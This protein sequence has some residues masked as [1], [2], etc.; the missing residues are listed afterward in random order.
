MKKIINKDFLKDKIKYI[1]DQ[2]TNF[3]K[4]NLGLRII[5]TVILA[6]AF[7]TFF[8]IFNFY[9]KEG[10]ISY[11]RIFI[12]SIIAFYIIS[13]F[14][15]NIRELY[16]FIYKKRYMISIVLVLLF[17]I[18][19]YNGSSI[20]E[21]NYYIQ[22]DVKLKEFSP[23]I[24]Q[25]RKIRTDEWST[26]TPIALSQDKLENKYSYYND[27]VR[28][29]KTDMFSLM[30]IPV[31]DILSLGKIFN[32]GYFV[33]INFGLS[34]WWF[35]RLFAL[36][37]VTFELCMM[38]T[39][40]NR[41]VSLMGMIMISFSAAVQWWFSTPIVEILIWGQLAVLLI[42]K[43]IRT[44][45][46][47]TK[48]KYTLLLFVCAISYVF[49][50]YPAWQISFG[51]I[52]LA[53]I[54]WVFIKNKNQI[55]INKKD[56]ILLLLFLVLVGGFIGRFIFKSGDSLKAMTSTVY[57]GERKE[58]GGDRLNIFSYIYNI[59]EPYESMGNDCEQASLF[60]LYPLPMLVSLVYI[61]NNKKGKDFIIPLL[62]VGILYTV[63]QFIG[64]GNFELLA[65]ITLL[66]NVPALRIA[67]PLALIQIYLMVYLIS[68]IKEKD[69]LFNER[70]RNKA[71]NKI[72]IIA[73]CYISIYI[74]F[75]INVYAADNTINVLESYLEINRYFKLLIII[76]TIC[77]TG[78]LLININR[79]KHK[80]ILISLLII[81]SL[82]TRCFCESDIK[83]YFSNL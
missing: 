12:L 56:I 57:P 81:I 52:Y 74:A 2:I 31:L 34:L 66:T 38:I 80:K 24:G 76:L 63:W 21:Y 25:T 8:D 35:G 70:I 23:I 26:S 77:I 54:A 65:K 4:E 16:E 40:K 47:K 37:L 75:K 6:I 59:L 68:V 42:D 29:S 71:L 69:I 78:Y 51:Y 50:F 14:T 48:L 32:I 83:R 33:S 39:N 79:S 46:F 44:N 22:S 11:D 5:L 9:I 19:G 10:Y 28:A 49:V 61:I 45:E 67:I 1:N 13:H 43:Y 62:I 58:V 3:K 30:N 7:T 64:F 15:I 72:L 17:A 36:L 41:I 27:I 20:N 82:A 18:L 53:L 60:S 55:K 73:F